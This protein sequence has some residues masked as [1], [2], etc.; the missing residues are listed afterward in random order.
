MTRDVICI[1]RTLAAG[2]EAVGRGVAQQLG[3]SYV[4][5]EIIAIASRKA[6]LD[7]A[8]VEKVEHRA[9]ILKR[10]LDALGTRP[11]TDLPIPAGG[12]YLPDAPLAAPVGDDLRGL[13]REAID[14]VAMRGK[15]VLVAHAASYAL[16]KRADVLRVLISA[17]LETRSERLLLLGQKETKKVLRESDKEREFYLRSFYDVREESP[18]DY[19]LVLNTD[20]LTADQAV[21]AIVALAR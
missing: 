15:V 18:L 3:Y 5:E 11:P 12:Y 14:E 2:G 17:S 1:S 6:K 8:E 9:S 10:L 19:D 20:G 7:P 4:D 13:I 21:A 16:G